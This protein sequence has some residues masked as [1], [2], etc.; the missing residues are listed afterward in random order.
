MDFAKLMSSEISK[1]AQQTSPPPTAEATT[2]YLKRADLEGQR[3][4]AYLDEQAALQREREAKLNQ[5]R[6]REEEETARNRE[7]DE[8]RR[9]LAEESRIRREAEE[10]QKERARRKR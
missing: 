2:K 8:K 1:K 5:K 4:Q 10:E 3:R 9:R 7:R 6:K